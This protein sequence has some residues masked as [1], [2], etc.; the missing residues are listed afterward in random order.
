RDPRLEVAR[1]L[2][3]V[4][5][6]L[7]GARVE[8]RADRCLVRIFHRGTLVKV[9]PRQPPGGRSTDPA[10]LPSEKTA[11]AMRDLDLLQ[12]M[13]ASHG[14]AVGTYAAALPDP[15]LS[16]E[17]IVEAAFAAALEEEGQ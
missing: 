17:A 9:H 5:G 2:Y 16:P 10:D 3:S 4:P 1:A 14:E 7:I 8:A 15:P 12:R 11:Y 13:A 6:N